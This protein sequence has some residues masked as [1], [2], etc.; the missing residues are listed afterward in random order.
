MTVYTTVLSFYKR[1]QESHGSYTFLQGLPVLVNVTAIFQG[2]S[3]GSGSSLIFT[4]YSYPIL[5]WLS[6]G[7]LFLYKGSYFLSPGKCFTSLLLLSMAN[8]YVLA[9][10]P[11]LL[12]CSKLNQQAIVST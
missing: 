2:K 3:K 9:K 8:H 12:I 11:I 5:C 6:V 1:K 7:V 4:S 10:Q